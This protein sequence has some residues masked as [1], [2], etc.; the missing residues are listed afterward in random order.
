MSQPQTE[1]E[2]QLHDTPTH[3]YDM[4][5]MRID[6]IQGLV[7]LLQ[8]RRVLHV[9]KHTRI[10]ASSAIANQKDIDAR[11]SAVLNKLEKIITRMLK[12]DESI[13]KTLN[14]ARG[15]IM[16]A[17]D[18]TLILEKTDGLRKST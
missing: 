1:Q 5:Q 14:E 9:T 2:E 4:M 16:E 6:Q 3:R 18:G 8:Q 17:S 13:T 7:T 11:L 12:D 15:L 10:K